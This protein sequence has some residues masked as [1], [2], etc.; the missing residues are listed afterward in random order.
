MCKVAHEETDFY[1]TGIGAKNN[2]EL[3]NKV[4]TG[5]LCAGWR[6]R[7]TT[8]VAPPQLTDSTTWPPSPPSPPPSIPPCP[9]PLKYEVHEDY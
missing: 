2:Q 4:R 3:D 7:R 8:E 9:T 6:R 5:L 1:P